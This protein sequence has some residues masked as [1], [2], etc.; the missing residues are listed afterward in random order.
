MTQSPTTRI[1]RAQP[2]TTKAGRGQLGT[3]R[4]WLLTDHAGTIDPDRLEAIA[5][6]LGHVVRA[7]IGGAVVEVGCYRGAMA[8]WLRAILDDLGDGDREVHVYDSFAGLPP[9][10]AHDSD[11]LRAGE[12]LASPDEVIATHHRWSRTPPVI[13]PG[14]FADTLPAELPT[15][16]AF[17]YLDG[18][19]HDSILTSL[20]HCVPRLAPGGRLVVDDYADIEV[21]PRAWNGLPGVKHACEEYFGRRSPLTVLTGDGDLAFGLYEAGPARRKP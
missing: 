3:L 17:A 20:V 5:E 4:S 11:H 14:W 19:F 15:A 2:A 16:I 21:N 7:G 10:G 13:H 6:H 1:P 12:L 18:D 8:L 9:A